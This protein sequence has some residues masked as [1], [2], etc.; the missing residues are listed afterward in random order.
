MNFKNPKPKFP[1]KHNLN[2]FYLG[3]KY[4][5][6]EVDIWSSVFDIDLV[7]GILQYIPFI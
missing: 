3:I 7:L 6:E 5:T 4:N 1:I 2:R